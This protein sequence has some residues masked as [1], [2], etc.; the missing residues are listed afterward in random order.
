VY[1]P[2]V[3][4]I[5]SG[6]YD[7]SVKLWDTAT[8]ELL[9]TIHCFGKAI[10]SVDWK[11]IQNEQLLVSGGVE[12]EVRCWRVIE[13][14]GKFKTVLQWSSTNNEL[15]VKGAVLNGVNSLSPMNSSLMSQRGAVIC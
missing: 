8:G 7:G 13:D 4:Q 6:S 15:L 2:N 11:V 5:G 12:G 3:N 10:Y 14:G 9:T 1:S